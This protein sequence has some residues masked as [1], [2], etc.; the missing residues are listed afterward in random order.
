MKKLR[1][2]GRILLAIPFIV[3]GINHFVMQDIFIGMLSSFLPNSVYMIFI[4]GGI[5]IISGIALIINKEVLLFCYV[6][7][8]LLIVFIFLIHIPN[9]ISPPEALTINSN[10]LNIHLSF[11]SF[12][13]DLGL[14]GG[15]LIIIGLYKEE[16]K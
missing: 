5:M 7:A 2:I 16:K 9:M 4:S 11:F 6:L 10:G 8:A 1:S 15:L 3:L 12:L 14:L 13:K